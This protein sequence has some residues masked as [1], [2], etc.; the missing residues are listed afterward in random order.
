MNYKT[1]MFS[2]NLFIQRYYYLSVSI[3]RETWKS[4]LGQFLKG[5]AIWNFPGLLLPKTRTKY[6]KVR[7]VEYLIKKR[8]KMQEKNMSNKR[9]LNFD[10]WKTFSESQWQS[11][12]DLLTNLPRIIIVCHFSPSS[13]KIKK[14]ILPLLT[15]CVS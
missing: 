11:D 1:I 10:Q 9:D 8:S 2:D 15:K 13:F 5:K 12:Y 3:C 6:Q 7:Y 4:F 14:G